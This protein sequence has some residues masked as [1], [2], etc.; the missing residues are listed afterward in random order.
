MTFFDAKLFGVDCIALKQF[1][2]NLQKNFPTPGLKRQILKMEMVY[3]H[4]NFISVRK[5]LVR[6]HNCYKY[7]IINGIRKEKAHYLSVK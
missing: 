2:S 3:Y 6:N 4:Y 5:F 1:W 7:K